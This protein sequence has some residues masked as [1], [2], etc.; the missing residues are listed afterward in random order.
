MGTGR[1]TYQY[2]NTCTLLTTDSDH[3]YISWLSPISCSL[4]LAVA[5]ERLFSSNKEIYCMYTRYDTLDSRW[6]SYSFVSSNAEIHVHWQLVQMRMAYSNLTRTPK[7]AKLVKD[8]WPKRWTI[9]LTPMVIRELINT[10]QLMQWHEGRVDNF[11]SIRAETIG[12]YRA[13]RMSPT[14][15][16]ASIIFKLQLA[17]FPF[18]GHFQVLYLND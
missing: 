6:R 3:S 2:M 15:N 11:W 1:G 12:C 9:K 8:R 10:V 18:S 5:C 13:K 7:E 14:D 16:V 4:K 17:G